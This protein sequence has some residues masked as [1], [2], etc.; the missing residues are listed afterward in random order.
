MGAVALP[1]SLAYINSEARPYPAYLLEE[2]E[3]GLA[4]F[5]AAFLGWND[6]IHFARK[7][8]H[9]T[10][11]DRDEHKLGEMEAIY[12]DQWAFFCQ[13]AWDFALDARGIITW[14]VV[15][16]D[17]F[18]GVS[19]ERVWNS[20]DLFLDLA[21]RLVTVTVPSK[22]R[23]RKIKGWRAYKYPRSSKAD[24]MVLKRA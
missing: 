7:G 8:M 14:D 19:Q 17:P 2:G 4:L 23:T 10:C 6:S 24:W 20:L 5:S 22:Q 15:S 11:V 18:L 21:T 12:P 16:I 1:D 13:D 9:G 3:S